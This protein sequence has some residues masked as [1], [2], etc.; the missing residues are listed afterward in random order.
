MAVATQ[1]LVDAQTRQGTGR[2]LTVLLIGQFMCIIDAVIVNVAMPTI[3][4][5]LHADGAELQL[6]VGGYTI[7]YA[8]LLITCARLGD[9]YGRRRA[10]LAGV[11]A[12]TVASAACACAPDG[13]ALIAFRFIQG[14]G[15]AL[16]VPQIFSII[17]LRFTGP[18]RVRALSAYA[19]VLSGGGVTGMILGGVIVTANL[20]GMSWRPVFGVN[21]PIG[22]A[23]ALL[24]PRTIPADGP[25]GRTGRMDVLGLVTASL[26]VLLIVLPLVL[27]H[28]LGWPA[29]TIASLVVG[30][31]LAAVFVRT[32]RRAE[33]RRVLP[34]LD[35]RVLR[36]RGLPGGLAALGLSQV[37]YGGVLFVF[38]LYL[39]VSRHDSPL[40]AGLTYLPLSTSFG[41]VSFYWRR[42]PPAVHG[43]L[44]SVG[45]VVTGIGCLLLPV[46]A[47]AGLGLIGIGLGLAVGPLFNRS[48]ANVPPDR[49]ADASGVL[50]T[51]VQLGQLAGV[52][53]VGSLYL[54]S[55]LPVTTYTLAALAA[56]AALAAL[57]RLGRR[58]DR[59]AAV[60]E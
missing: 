33:Q 42:L 46:S 25:G 54:S 43:A 20:F 53:A 23:L 4:A 13:P 60:S 35:L 56:V 45:L 8:M 39:Q 27:G 28:Q 11:V 30:P 37:V 52:A 18:A 31:L 55:S 49:A 58:C 59:G 17:Q 34:L 47:Y 32:E 50:T 41:L 14:A 1:P 19:A 44:A 57:D 15:A 51:T 26:T 29:W 38:T 36:S 5:G 3:G 16:L 6:I 7:S 10:Y 22:I 48:L 12:F 9:R 40:R 21:V 24:V 2:M